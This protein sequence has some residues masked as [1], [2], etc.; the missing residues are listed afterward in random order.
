MILKQNGKVDRWKMLKRTW[1]EDP[2][3]GDLSLEEV[4]SRFRLYIE[5]TKDS[6]L[7]QQL[8]AWTPNKN[9]KM[10]DIILS[11]ATVRSVTL[12]EEGKEVDD[13]D[14]N[15]LRI[16]YP[17]NIYKIEILISNELAPN[18]QPTVMHGILR[19]TQAYVKPVSDYYISLPQL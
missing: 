19:I 7:G 12:M 10:R 14:W 18:N 9:V 3:I 1:K 15:L 6:S 5:K 4:D 13:H 8:V 2:K 11:G 16:S 17:T